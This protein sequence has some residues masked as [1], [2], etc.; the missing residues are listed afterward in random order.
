[1]QSTDFYQKLSINLLAPG[2]PKRQ[3]PE[4]IS[5][6]LSPQ[7]PGFFLELKWRNYFKKPGVWLKSAP[8]VPI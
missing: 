4:G 7:K 3:Q 6:F 8:R 2:G 5:W 1:M